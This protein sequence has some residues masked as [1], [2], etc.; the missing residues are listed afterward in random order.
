MEIIPAFYFPSTA[1]FVDDDK[2]FLNEIKHLYK[3]QNINTFNIPQDALDY[4]KKMSEFDLHSYSDIF[5]YD[6]SHGTVIVIDKIFDF[7]NK[8]SSDHKKYKKVGS[9]FIDYKMP[10]MN[11]LE[12]IKRIDKMGKYYKIFLTGTADNKKVINYFNSGIID[13]YINKQDLEEENII[14]DE[15]IK[16]SLNANNSL[17]T[18][19]SK[20]ITI[21]NESY[22]NNQIYIKFFLRILK[23]HDIREYYIRNYHGDFILI[24]NNNNVFKLY[25]H[26][27]KSFLSSLEQYDGLLDNK[28]AKE[29]QNKKKNIC[30]IY[31]LD[32]RKE[33]NLDN[34]IKKCDVISKEYNLYYTLIENK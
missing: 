33:N 18:F 21:N 9:I 7:I 22:L 24:N 30:G 2:D 11:G 4:I 27:N 28:T 1:I 12:F 25:L 32:F 26:D 10:E 34:L 31:D 29:I 3:S 6:S 20:A 23:E 8:L 13:Q 16:G 5:K 19:I 14:L 15:I 17:A